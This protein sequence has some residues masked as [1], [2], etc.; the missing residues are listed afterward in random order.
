MKLKVFCLSIVLAI[1]PVAALAMPSHSAS[2]SEEDLTF[3][4]YVHADD[5]FDVVGLSG[6]NALLGQV[7]LPS[8]PAKRFY[9]LI[10]QD[11]RVASVNITY[12]H[13]TS[14]PGEYNEKGWGRAHPSGIAAVVPLTPGDD[15]LLLPRAGRR[16]QLAEV[17]AVRDPPAVGGAAVPRH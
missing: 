14:L 4:E 12:L 2:F 11:R 6:A 13:T 7:G 17:D 1:L 10:P 9:I 16:C 3:S 5:T 15:D 8:L